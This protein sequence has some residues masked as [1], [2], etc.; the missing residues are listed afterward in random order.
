M[1]CPD[2]WRRRPRHVNYNE[3][4]IFE[5]GFINEFRLAQ[6]N[7]RANIAAGRGKRSPTPERPARRRCRPSSRSSTRQNAAQRRQ[8]GALHRH[9]LDERDVPELPRGAQPES[10]RL[11]LRR[12]QR[13]DGQRDASANAAAAGVP[14][15]YFVANPDLL[16]GAFLS[17]TSVERSTTRIAGRAAPP[18]C[19]GPAVPD[20]LCLRQGLRHRLGDVAQDPQF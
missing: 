20:Q 14:A 16:G 1:A 7:L 19:R 10:V 11:R 5:N 3:F 2:Q 9:Q 18:L 17:P 13:P 15:N 12:H 4:N 8:R 6:R